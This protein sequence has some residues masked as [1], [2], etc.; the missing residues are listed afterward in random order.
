MIA[1]PSRTLLFVAAVTGFSF[2]GLVGVTVTDLL[3][4]AEVAEAKGKVT[5]LERDHARQAFAQADANSV[6]LAGAIAHGNTLTRQ[7]STARA[8]AARLKKDLQ[9]EIDQHTDGRVCLSEPALRVLERAPGLAIDLPA[10]AGSAYRADAG[11]VATDADIAAW[12]LAA[13]DA[14]AECGRRLDALITWT[15]KES[16]Q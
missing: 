4:K 12:A 3:A 8:E 11:H 1:L 16:A 14:Y 15:E 5:Q 13:G 7:L 2:G 6:A 10:A 9:N